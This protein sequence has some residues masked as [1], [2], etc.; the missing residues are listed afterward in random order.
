MCNL[1]IQE[2][3]IRF[4]GIKRDTGPPRQSWGRQCQ[5]PPCLTDLC[6]NQW[7]SFVVRDIW[8]PR[9]RLLGWKGEEE[10]AGVD[11]ER[12]LVNQWAVDVISL[13]ESLVTP[14]FLKLSFNSCQ[15]LA[16]FTFNTIEVPTRRSWHSITL[17]AERLL[18]GP[19]NWIFTTH[20]CL[21]WFVDSLCSQIWRRVPCFLMF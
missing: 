5:C 13:H 17:S 11:F 3:K 4:F 20:G 18:T 16:R 10:Y 21:L 8:T 12:K 6:E 14:P 7:T 19:V 2:W 1:V 15:L 9:A